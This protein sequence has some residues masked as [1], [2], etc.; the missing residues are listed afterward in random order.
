MNPSIIPDMLQRLKS[1]WLR[2]LYRNSIYLI[3]NIGITSLLGFFFWLIVAKVYSDVEVGYS[4][5]IVSALN[6]LAILSMVG[7]NS[8]VIRYLPHSEE[9]RNIIN[10]AF[11]FSGCTAIAAAIVFLL[12]VNIWAPDLSFINRNIVFILVFVGIAPLAALSLLSN[13]VFIASRDSLFTLVK[14]VGISLVKIVL[15]LAFAANFH[16]FGIVS[17]WGIALAMG[18]GL[19]VL[20]FIPKLQPV[21]KPAI[22][23]N[24]GFISKTWKYAGNSYISALFS[25]APAQVFPLMVLALTTVQNNAHFY[26]AWMIANLL[27]AVPMAISQSLFAEMAHFPDHGSLKDNLFRSLKFVYSLIIPLLILLLAISE[28]L[29]G[30]FG[31]GYV[32][33]GLT[34]LRILALSSL[35]MSF[36][37]VYY[38]MLLARDR[39]KE[40]LIF[41]VIG[42]IVV[43]SLGFIII[44]VTGIV[45]IGYVWVG[46]HAIL[47]LAALVRLVLWLRELSGNR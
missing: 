12:G 32:E 37:H 33:D 8:W 27:F 24:I 18:V 4:S 22:K 45:G 31:P 34:L 29:L 16:S 6:L 30:A 9:S 7:L 36:T 40:L 10:T 14:D 2:P 39:L 3:V 44:P 19:S 47:A 35:F 21:Y 15:A 28:W 20:L 11:T 1:L 41:R 13:C 46:V 38:S 43:L 42:S 5:A 26:I 25:G 23:V 17:S